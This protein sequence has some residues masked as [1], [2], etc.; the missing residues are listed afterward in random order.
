MEGEDVAAHEIGFEGAGREGFVEAL[1]V[2]VGVG[3]GAEEV[4]VP[5][6]AG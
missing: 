2:G 3:E 6:G 1:D 4:G 5:D